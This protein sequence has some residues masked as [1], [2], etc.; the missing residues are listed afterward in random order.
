M[1]DLTV[2]LP[3]LTAACMAVAVALLRSTLSTKKLSRSQ[4]LTDALI[5]GFCTLALSIVTK[6]HLA[7]YIPGDSIAI[8]FC[9]G[10]LGTGKLSDFCLTVAKK[11]LGLG[12]ETKK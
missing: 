8:A 1:D 10:F 11:R 4:R 9:V 3:H 12:E 6:N 2:M 5:C 7:A